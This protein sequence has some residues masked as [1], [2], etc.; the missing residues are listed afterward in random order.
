VVWFWWEIKDR[1]VSRGAEGEGAKKITFKKLI[2]EENQQK[3][4]VYFGF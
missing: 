4:I 1:K 2:N 3:K